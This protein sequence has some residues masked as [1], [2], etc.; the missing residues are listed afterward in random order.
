[1]SHVYCE[2]V[3]QGAKRCVRVPAR[4]RG[5][6]LYSPITFLMVFSLTIVTLIVI[7]VTFF[8]SDSSS[9]RNIM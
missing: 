6:I 4:D 5:T 1:M 7:I 2:V 9:V 3:R 8:G